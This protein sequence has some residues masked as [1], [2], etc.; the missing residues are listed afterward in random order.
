MTNKKTGNEYL[1]NQKLDRRALMIGAG[2]SAVTAAMVSTLAGLE[3]PAAAATTSAQP[4]VAG[5]YSRA[6]LEQMAEKYLQAL[7]AGDPSR[8][9]FAEHAI[10]AENDQQ[11]PLGD[12][13]WQT[14]DRLGRYRHYFV[15]PEQN[16][17]AV[18]ANVYEHGSGCVFIVTLKI[19]KGLITTAEQ[20]VIRDPGGARLYEELGA[21]DSIWLE[22][23]PPEQRQS[24]EALE[25]AAWIYFQS[26]E[27]N[28]GAGVYPF[29]DDCERIEHARRTVSQPKP[30]GYGHADLAVDFVTLKAKEQY[31][32]GMMAFVTR[33]RDRRAA[34]VDIERGAVLGQSGW[35]FDGT[36]KTIHFKDGRD[37]EIPPYFRTPRTHQVT[38]AFKVINGGF[39]YIEMTLMEVPYGTRQVVPGRPM[40]V[41]LDYARTAPLPKPVAAAKRSDL[42]QVTGQVLDAMIRCCPCDLPLA[43]DFRYTENG[44]D[45]VP[46]ESLWKSLMGLRDYGIFLTDPQTGQ[47][48]WFGTLNEYNLFAMMALRLRMRDGLIAEIE[49]V[50]ARPE[51]EAAVINSG[52]SGQEVELKGA[53]FTMFVPPL[54]ADL[55]PDAFGQPASALLH[56]APARDRESL[57]TAVNRYYDAFITRN[58][59]LAPLAADCVRRENG[60]PANNNANG[61]IID[62]A[63]PE[64]RLYAGDCAA[65]LNAGFLPGLTRM[66]ERRTLLVDKTQGL[67]LDMALL[68]NAARNRTVKLDGVGEL[69]LPASC[70]APWTDMHAQLFKITAGRISY[71]E[72]LVRRLPYGQGSGWTA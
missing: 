34:V 67:V 31:E 35:D 29:R 2:K 48:G 45:V 54:L 66:K 23:L 72:D 43:S 4:G 47:A 51:V 17:V 22:P 14:I 6:Y 11:L 3:N 50:I 59:S 5:Q 46:G 71:I 40:T 25:A 55:D 44:I 30:E 42:K 15:E 58:A 68:D 8:V 39:R 49:T 18:I 64:F 56:R 19:D 65:E 57:M 12:A 20:F 41:A 70:L 9:P 60:I 62:P 26:L 36:L 32:L 52:T 61:P 53:T 69:T 16:L 28:D 13:S 21:P 63:H 27:R 37:W 33:I 1:L 24:R 7:A 38:E 10:F